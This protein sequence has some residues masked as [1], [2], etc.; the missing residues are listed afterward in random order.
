MLQVVFNAV[1]V[2]SLQDVGG[3]SGVCRHDVIPL[4]AQLRENVLF[5]Q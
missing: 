3:H 2:K 1:G 4:R 5:L